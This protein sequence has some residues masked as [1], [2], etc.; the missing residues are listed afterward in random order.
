[1]VVQRIHTCV[2]ALKHTHTQPDADTHTHTHRLAPTHMHRT[3][4]TNVICSGWQVLTL[5]L[6]KLIREWK[7]RRGRSCDRLNETVRIAA[8]IHF[9]SP[10]P[11]PPPRWDRIKRRKCARSTLLNPF[12]QIYPRAPSLA[13]L[14]GS[15]PFAP[16]RENRNRSS[17]FYGYFLILSL[18]HLKQPWPIDYPFKNFAT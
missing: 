2:C 7:W 9:I 14:V 6:S 4:T 16:W 10:P 11:P 8:V 3:C 13:C 18:T 5:L 15:G 17:Q 12:D 1:M